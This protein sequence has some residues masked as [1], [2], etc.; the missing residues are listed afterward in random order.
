MN[1]TQ[2][3]LDV[4]NFLDKIGVNV[5]IIGPLN[6]IFGL[7]LISTIAAIA[8]FVARK[9]ILKLVH[10]VVDKTKTKWDDILLE[11]NVFN[12]L[13]HV[14][15]GLIL[16]YSIGTVLSGT[17]LV[18]SRGAINVYLI[19][20]ILL[21]IDA[22]VNSL[23]HIYST[24]ELS[25]SRPI[26]GYVQVIKIVLYFV[27]TILI[28]ATI[29]NK[30][31][32][33]LFTGLGAIAAIL[34]LV[35]KDTLLGFVASIQLSANKMVEV[36]DWISMPNH[37]A[38][39]DVLEVSLNTV[40]VQNWDKTIATIPTY[41]LVS[42]S[43]NNWRG[44]SESG[45]RRIKRHVLL[46]MKSVKFCSDELMS[47]FK[48]IHLLK[49]YIEE[50]EKENNTYNELHNINNSS[51]VDKKALTNIGTFRKYLEKYL[52]A[53][54]NIHSDMTFLV[55]QLQHTEKGIPI[56]IYAFSNDQAWANYE[57]VQ[58]DIFD[59]I[60]AI[61]PEFELNVYQSPSG[62]DIVQVQML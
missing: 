37:N 14:V 30:E 26:K 23:H 62:D 41:A 22:F 44:M 55:R 6:A 15:P 25:K 42:E 34:I 16:Y 10:K 43:F 36:G 21:A 61:I 9:I 39:G 57:S 13:T 59:H 19:L 2:S 17:L 24:L 54:P 56:E 29:L 33:N 47:N 49:E 46:D 50:K 35:F 28:L 48:N 31:A 18:L 5:S 8:Y 51:I 53:N 52:K 27:A 3:I 32:T 38:D 12:K 40:K 4:S 1:N 58:A 20:M 7:I 45:G 11:N 60:L